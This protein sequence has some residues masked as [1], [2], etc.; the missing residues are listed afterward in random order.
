MLV[1]LH[2]VWK[3]LVIADAAERQN[4]FLESLEG[5]FVGEPEFCHIVKYQILD[6]VLFEC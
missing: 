4:F 1:Q 5:L 3:C 2:Y 6:I